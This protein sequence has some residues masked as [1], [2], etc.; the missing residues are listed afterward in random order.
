MRLGRWAVGRWAVGS[1]QQRGQEGSHGDLISESEFLLS[2]R[3]R[4]QFRDPI[5]SASQ[6][7]LVTVRRMEQEEVGMEKRHLA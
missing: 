2:S 7:I 4:N 3:G 5:G 1:G 6:M